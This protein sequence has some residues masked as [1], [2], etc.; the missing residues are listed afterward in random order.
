MFLMLSNYE[1]WMTR[2]FRNADTC[3]VH[4]TCIKVSWNK[5]AN[6]GATLYVPRPGNMLHVIIHRVSIKQDT[7]LLAIGLHSQKWLKINYFFRNTV[8]GSAI[9]DQ[10]DQIYGTVYAAYSTRKQIF[11]VYI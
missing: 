9:N 11:T 10:C 1:F 7:E 5:L 6:F 8:Y 4:S 2:M 3:I